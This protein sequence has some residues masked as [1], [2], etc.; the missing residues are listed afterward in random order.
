MRSNF[1]RRRKTKDP[2]QRCGLHAVRCICSI[3]PLLNLA[4]RVSVVV[5]AKELKRTTNTGRLAI[6]ALTNSQMI[7]RG[8]GRQRVDLS[9]LLDPT[10]E[11]YLLFPSD[12]AVPLA[13]VRP[14][15]PVH[16]IVP[17]GNWR[18]ASKLNTRHPELAAVP[19]VKIECGIPQK[20]HLRKEHFPEGL[21]TL[22]AIGEALRV[23]E[24]E[25]VGL[26][27]LALY[28]AKLQ[29]TLVGRGL[30]EAGFFSSAF[31]QLS[32]NDSSSPSINFS[33]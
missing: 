22:Q 15:K 33:T 23:L 14:L 7:V 17:D 10:Y 29:A 31:S 5:H 21:S 11:T 4:T 9:A 2:C 30:Q 24:G 18:Q 26:K 27:M 19:R 6:E 32:E 28:Q 12:T 8:L 13:D 25:A 20:H 3:I 16:L 1:S